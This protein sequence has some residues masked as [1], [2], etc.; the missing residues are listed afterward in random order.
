MADLAHR[1]CI[2]EEG[3]YTIIINKDIGVNF[4]SQNSFFVAEIGF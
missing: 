3:L 2:R 1:L 4:I